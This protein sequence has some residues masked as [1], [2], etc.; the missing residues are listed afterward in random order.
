ME[1]LDVFDSKNVVFFTC[2]FFFSFLNRTVQ[3]PELNHVSLSSPI[4]GIAT[5]GKLSA[6]ATAGTESGPGG[7]NTTK[8]SR[9]P[10]EDDDDD[11]V[12]RSFESMRQEQ[13]QLSRNQDE[14]LV[15]MSDSV[16]N[17]RSISSHI[18]NELDEQAVM[19]DEFGTEIE[20]A[21]SK[22]DATMRKMS[23]VLHVSNGKIF[24]FIRVRSR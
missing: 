16:G 6:A 15:M 8:Y 12:K 2:F 17:L 13:Q 24:L 11:G 1:C 10:V 21:E 9:L 23:K 20:N 7:K 18:G 19:L 4:R 3:P 14:Q 22:L 5:A